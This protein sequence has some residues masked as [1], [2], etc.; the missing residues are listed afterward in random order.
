MTGQ[1]PMIETAIRSIRTAR[2]D[3]DRAANAIERQPIAD[4]QGYRDFEAALN[5]ISNAA[6]GLGMLIDF[7]EIHLQKE[8]GA[9]Q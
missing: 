7:L 9:T 4:L 2:R 5:H 6:S 8:S 3:L 1:T